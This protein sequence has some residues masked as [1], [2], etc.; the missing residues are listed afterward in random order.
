[1]QLLSTVK[2][3]V[4]QTHK[5][6]IKGTIRAD[7]AESLDENAVHGSDSLE[8][9]PL[10]LPIFLVKMAFV[11]ERDKIDNHSYVGKENLLGLTQSK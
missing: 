5:K 2:L 6:L 3:W 7:F 8:K 10:R 4:L 9:L 11:Q 1:M